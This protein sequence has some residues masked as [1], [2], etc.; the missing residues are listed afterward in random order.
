MMK[1]P[2]FYLQTDYLLL[3]VMG[4]YNSHLI[5]QKTPVLFIFTQRELGS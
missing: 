3:L 5:A 2:C 1:C 4:R